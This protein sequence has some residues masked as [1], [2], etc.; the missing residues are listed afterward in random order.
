M[1]MLILDSFL[2]VDAVNDKMSSAIH[3]HQNRTIRT[4]KC[5]S[6]CFRETVLTVD[7]VELDEGFW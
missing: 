4:K 5:H 7:E 6:F 2:V 1:C 3:V